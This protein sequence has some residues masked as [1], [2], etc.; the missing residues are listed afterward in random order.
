MHALNGKL[1][2]SASA[3]PGHGL[4]DGRQIE[5]YV[6]DPGPVL[7]SGETTKVAS[8]DVNDASIFPDWGTWPLYIHSLDGALYFSGIVGSERELYVYFPDDLTV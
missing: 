3:D 4:Q 1:Y 6:Y 7:G 2:F 8:A 5:L